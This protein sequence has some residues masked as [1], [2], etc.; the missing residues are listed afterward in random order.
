VKPVSQLATR[1]S[2]DSMLFAVAVK[3][4]IDYR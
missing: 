2:H 1:A 3:V 4:A